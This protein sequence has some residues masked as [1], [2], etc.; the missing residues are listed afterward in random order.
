MAG[1]D[2][3]FYSMINPHYAD[4]LFIMTRALLEV[5]RARAEFYGGPGPSPAKLKEKVL[6]GN[7]LRIAGVDCPRREIR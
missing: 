1:L 7:F 3:V 5:L 2:Q 4:S 6:S